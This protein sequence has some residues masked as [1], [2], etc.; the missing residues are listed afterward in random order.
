MRTNENDSCG[1]VDPAGRVGSP[2]STGDCKISV[3]LKLRDGRIHDCRI[4]G[5]F[6]VQPFEKTDRVLSDIAAAVNGLPADIEESAIAARI[7]TAVP[8]GIEM[9]MSAREIAMAVRAAL[10]DLPTISRIGSFTANQIEELTEPWKSYSWEVIPESPLSAAINVALDEVQSNR[11]TPRLRFW[12]WTEP[13]VIVGRCQ[14]IQNEVDRDAMAASGVSLVRRLTGGGAMFVQPHGTITYSLVFP[15]EAVAGLT[16]RQ[17]YE[18][19]DAWVVRGLRELGV[20]AQHVPVNDIACASGK[21]GGAAQSRR[22]GV[23]LHHTTIAYDLRMDEMASVLRIGR[24]KRSTNAIVSAAKVV[25]PLASQTKLPREAIV[26]HLLN[27]FRCDYGGTIAG[28]SA[29]DLA[30]GQELV[31]EKYAHPDW[32]NEFA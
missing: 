22:R 26:E 19:C 1:E 32:T 18:V 24:E 9:T 2:I 5:N 27:R 16:I 28:L 20:D 17:S 23:V 29:A 30:E 10:H 25:S 3:G 14:S 11:G 31:R 6:A 4:E 8:F 15:E 21:I 7:R 12:K 13:A